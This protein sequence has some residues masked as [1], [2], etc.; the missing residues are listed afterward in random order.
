MV[1]YWLPQD[2]IL[3][4]LLFFFSINDILNCSTLYKYGL[5]VYCNNLFYS[6]TSIINLQVIVNSELVMISQWLRANKLL[7]NISK[8]NLW[9]LGEFVFK[10]HIS[11]FKL[12]RVTN[13]KFVGV[14]IDHFY[15]IFFQV[16]CTIKFNKL[17]RKT[18]TFRISLKIFQILCTV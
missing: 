9:S 6:D 4:Q 1:A 15:N 17:R 5:F 14:Y 8:L 7:P 2:S 18:H 13:T 3:G 11:T 16:W 10:S 12:K